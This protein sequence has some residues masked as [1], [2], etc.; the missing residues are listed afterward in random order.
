MNYQP[1]PGNG[2]DQLIKRIADLEQAVRTL[3]R[4]TGTS[5]GSLVS[6]VDETLANIDAEV[7]DS[8]NTNSYTKSVIDGK[9]SAT[10]N[11]A[12]STAVAQSNA[13]T[14]AGYTASGAI[15]ASDLFTRNGPTQNITQTRVSTWT[16]TSD[17]LVGTASSSERFKTDIE[18]VDLDHLRAILGVQVVH[19]SYL[20]EVRRRDDPS[21]E[22]YVGPDY[23][24]AVNIG[25]LAERLHEAGLWEFVIYERENIVEQ[26]PGEQNEDGSPGEP[27]E[28]IV[29]DRLKLDDDGEPIPFGIHD[30]LLAYSLI[31]IVADHEQ[32]LAA[33]EARMEQANF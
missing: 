2:F 3:Q 31:P 16:R 4:P 21:F 17:G 19:F 10:L 24:V 33:V 26:L 30:I 7:I 23:H 13:F 1:P 25:S 6:R 15:S 29:G 18:A 32:R 27:V 12:V 11:S 28:V 9:D 22:E 8:I 20:D 5:V 14:L